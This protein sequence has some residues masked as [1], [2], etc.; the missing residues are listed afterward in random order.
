MNTVA[1]NPKQREVRTP[2]FHPR[3]SA[4]GVL[5]FVL[6]CV[7]LW[8]LPAVSHTQEEEVVANLATGRVVICVTRDG[9]VVATLENRSEPDA[10]APVAVELS[11]YR[12]GVLL[13]AAEW[14]QPGTGQP[15]VRLERELSRLFNQVSAGKPRAGEEASDIKG[16]GLALLDVLR[17]L[18]ARL[19]RKIELPED[20]PLLEL[21]LLGY[22]PD[23][24]PEVWRLQYRIEQQPLRGEY[25]R[26]RVLQPRYVQLYPPENGQ[27]RTLIEV[28]YPPDDP[29]P[30]LLELLQKNDP[31]LA[32]LRVADPP[33]MRASEKLARGESHKAALDDATQFLRAALGA[34]V[35]DQKALALGV[36]SQE[37]GFQW[38][39]APV[40]PAVKAEEDKQREPSAPSLRRKPPQP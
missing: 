17:P 10:R 7:H 38:L 16:L 13:G 36:I 33:M 12:L 19:H 34:L 2:V 8:F 25:W 5:S 1:R 23:Y 30:A 27:P 35:V 24:G 15:P 32:R 37:R 29:E 18:A 21:L 26:T 6:I 39:L 3:F 20:E 14:L 11:G 28:R 4:F 31:R 9:I 22:V 40:E